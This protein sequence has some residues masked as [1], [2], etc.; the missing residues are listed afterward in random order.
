[1]MD[2]KINS[3]ERIGEGGMSKRRQVQEN[4]CGIHPGKRLRPV[5]QR[6]KFLYLVVDDWK[7]G[8]TIHK[9]DADDSL[10]TSTDLDLEPSVLRLRAPVRGHGMDFTALGSNIFIAARKHTGTFVYDT[11]TEGVAIGP[12]LSDSMMPGAHIF[13]AT[14][15][16]QLYALKNNIL[17]R[18]HSFEVMS[19]VGGPNPPHMS[20]PTMDW[21]WKSVPSPLPFADNERVTGYALHP[22]GSTIFMTAGSRSKFRTFSFDTTQ[23]EWRC[24]GEWVL[25]F[26][27]QAY[28]DGELDAWVGLHKDGYICSCQVPSFS[29]SST[30]TTQLDWRMVKEKMFRNDRRSTATLTYMGDT[31]FCIVESA[32]REGLE[33]EDARGVRD[34]FNLHI[35]I[36]GLKYNREGELQTTIDRT[37]KSYQVSKHL[38]FSPVAFWM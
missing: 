3:E 5:Q 29:S 4:Y 37:T 10:E 26:E 27:G 31:K 22:D 23:S 12:N 34:G 14:P 33:L 24:H 20:T 2:Q 25:P 6:Q 18:E 8:F 35:T 30:S 36:F 32:L 19:T 7:W 9:I 1:M 38:S 13:L 11:E 28:F 17:E 15:N 16:M 21:S